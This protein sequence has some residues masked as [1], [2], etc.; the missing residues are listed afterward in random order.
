[1]TRRLV[2]GSLCFRP[3]N[4][5][6]PW[7]RPGGGIFDRECV[8]QYV[9]RGACETFDEMQLFAGSP[10]IGAIGEIRG[11][12]HQRV[13]LPMSYRVSSQHSDVLRNVRTAMGRDDARRVVRFV[14]QSHI[15]RPLYNL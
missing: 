11:V 2:H 12:D 14:K 4:F 1:M 9:V 5:G 10:E 13:T 3:R 7:L 15:S 8:R 6:G